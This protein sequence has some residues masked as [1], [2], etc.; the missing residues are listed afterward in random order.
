MTWCAREEE[1]KIRDDRR[2]VKYKNKKN[3][4]KK[5]E[6]KCESAQ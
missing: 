4:K 6:K 1:K 3:S 2:I 5:I